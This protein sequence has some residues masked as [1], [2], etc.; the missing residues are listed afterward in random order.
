MLDAIEIVAVV[1]AVAYLALTIRQSLWCWPAALVS[2]ALFM[3]LFFNSKLYMQSALQIYY[4]GMAVYGWIEWKRG[5]EQHLGVKVHWWPPA[6]HAAVFVAVVVVSGALGW[7]LS[8]TDAAFPYLDSFATVAALVTTFMVA[9]KVI[10]NWLYWFV[11]DI[12]LVYMSWQSDLPWTAGL[13]ALYLVMVII[14]FVSWLK[15]SQTEALEADGS[16]DV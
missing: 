16:N 14:G 12:V 13:Y 1:F 15:S 7:A 10:E 9:R 2:V 8:R 4:L 5:G 3:F 11:I 6:L